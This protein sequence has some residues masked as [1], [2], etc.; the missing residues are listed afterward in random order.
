MIKPKIKIK[1]FKYLVFLIIKL[2]II[3]SKFHKIIFKFHFL[4]L[5]NKVNV[6]NKINKINKANIKFKIIN[7]NTKIIYQRKV[8]LQFK[9]QIKNN[10][11][12]NKVK[13]N[14][15]NNNRIK[16]LYN[17]IKQYNK[18]KLFN[19]KI[20]SWFNKTC[21]KACHN[22]RKKISRNNKEKKWTFKS[23]HN[24]YP[25]YKY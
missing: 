11:N 24:Y 5:S 19:S 3:I 15:Y 21:F 12:Y 18:I 22:L 17:K 9:Y 1:M 8:Y 23:N 14:Q 25:I 13:I 10:N 20:Y 7:N 4:I 6:I 16:Q 2:H